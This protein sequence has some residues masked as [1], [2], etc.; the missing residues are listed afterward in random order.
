MNHVPSV[1]LVSS[2]PPSHAACPTQCVATSERDKT[3]TNLSVPREKQHIHINNAYRCSPPPPPPPP[4]SSQCSVVLPM[5]ASTATDSRFLDL[6]G[7]QSPTRDTHTYTHTHTHGKAL[8]LFKEPAPLSSRLIIITTNGT[9][10]M[11]STSPQS[12]GLDGPLEVTL[13]CI[14][15]TVHTGQIYIIAHC[16]PTD[17]S[18]PP[19]SPL[20]MLYH[21]L[22]V[23]VP[24]TEPLLHRPVLCLYRALLRRLWQRRPH[25]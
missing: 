6:V 19:S 20:S 1:R 18:S 2:P 14:H 22:R 21:V 15:F 17:P 5:L 9:N 7:N 3:T 11:S 23:L 24:S 8:L 12:S 16:D 25:H 4:T 10:L 13:F